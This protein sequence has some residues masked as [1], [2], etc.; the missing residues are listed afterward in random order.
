MIIKFALAVALLLNAVVLSAADNIPSIFS[1][2]NGLRVIVQ[3]D[4]S[5]PMVALE[6]VVRSGAG[7]TENAEGVA[8]SL[9]HLVFQG[10]KNYPVPFQ[11]QS[12]ME[13]LGGINNAITGRDSTRYQL[14]VP[15]K[16]LLPALQIMADFV[17]NPT[18]AEEVC[19][20]ERAT[21]MHEIAEQ[22]YSPVAVL[23]NQGYLHSFPQSAYGFPPVGRNLAVNGLSPAA[24]KKFHSDW[25]R[26]GNISIIMVGNIS[27]LAAAA[28]I[29]QCFGA[30]PAVQL[31]VLAIPPIFAGEARIAHINTDF[32]SDYQLVVFPAPSAIDFVDYLSMQL[33]I[34][35][36]AEGEYPLLPQYW[37]NAN[38]SV[39]NYGVEYIPSRQN[40]RFMIWLQ[41]SAEHNN[42]AVQELLKC[43]ADITARGITTA[44]IIQAKAHMLRQLPL[45]Y[46]TFSQQAAMY[47]IYEA[48]C[49]AENVINYRQ[50]LDKV[51]ADSVRAIVPREYLALITMDKGLQ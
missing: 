33:L 5:L 26:P 7:S 9:E 46:E 45:Q 1:L 30:M 15:A 41:G 35:L 40:G 3:E 36:L 18:L 47:A 50:S 6:L 42:I 13:K 25:Y 16:N 22:S 21:I 2:K 44:A 39:A 27:T 43:F 31:P 51:S 17:I 34:S 24:I 12:E 29:E 23:V 20:R 19:L 32:P 28:M 4:N 14:T 49:G 38:C 37:G 10:S 11:A 8:H 48:S